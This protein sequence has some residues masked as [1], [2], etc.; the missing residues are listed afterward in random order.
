MGSPGKPGNCHFWNFGSRISPTLVRGQLVQPGSQDWLDMTGTYQHRNQPAN[1]AG[2]WRARAHVTPDAD[3]QQH[4]Q[5]P[6]EKTRRL[7]DLG[8]EDFLRKRRDEEPDA[9][10]MQHYP[11]ANGDNTCWMNAVLQAI[12]SVLMDLRDN[13]T[14][15]QAGTTEAAYSIFMCA[16]AELAHASG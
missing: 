4:H 10:E 1:E 14:I 15:L 12:L 13:P 16:F 2:I 5:A 8:I 6:V 7:W 9:F 3:A 11:L